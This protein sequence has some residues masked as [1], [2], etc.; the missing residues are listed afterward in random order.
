M[1]AVFFTVIMAV[2]IAVFT[3][4]YFIAPK[5]LQRRIMNQINSIG[6]N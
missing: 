1:G 6:G 5:S 3:A 2:T 4:A